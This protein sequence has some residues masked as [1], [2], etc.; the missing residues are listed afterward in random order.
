MITEDPSDSARVE[1][2][3]VGVPL[4]FV[5][6]GKSSDEI[7]VLSSVPASVLVNSCC[8]TKLRTEEQRWARKQTQEERNQQPCRQ[9]G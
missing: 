8:W 6:G 2:V 1:G 7:Q 4:V 5:D 9:S 3:S